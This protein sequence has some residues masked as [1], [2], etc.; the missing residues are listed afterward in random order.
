MVIFRLL[1]EKVPFKNSRK[2][3]MEYHLPLQ[4]DYQSKEYFDSHFVTKLMASNIAQ[5]YSMPL[6]YLILAEAMDAEAYTGLCRPNTG[7]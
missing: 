1:T 5:C 6:Y 4:Y 2:E 7:L 3:K